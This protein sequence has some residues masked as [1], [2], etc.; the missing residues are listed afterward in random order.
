MFSDHYR[1]TAM[2]SSLL[3]CCI[4]ING[5]YA[6]SQGTV[7][8]AVGI[9]E[10][11]SLWLDGL[12]ISFR[13][14]ELSGIW[15]M[16]RTQRRLS[17]LGGWFVVALKSF[18]HR[19]VLLKSRDCVPLFPECLSHCLVINVYQSLLQTSENCVSLTLVKEKEM[20]G[21]AEVF[22]VAR[23]QEARKECPCSW[24]SLRPLSFGLRSKLMTTLGKVTD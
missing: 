17:T 22:L 10:R 16:K 23:Q 4:G 7:E 11:K 1:A 19:L 20:V 14:W 18:F 15:R 3:G 21:A 2:C 8:S 13:R 5:L 24:G 9:Q 12:R 6:T